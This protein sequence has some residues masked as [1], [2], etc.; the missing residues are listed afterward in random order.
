M[1]CREKAWKP[2]R[3][4]LQGERPGNSK[5]DKMKRAAFRTSGVAVMAVMMLLA[6]TGLASAKSLYVIADTNYWPTPIRAYNV[7]PDGTLTFQAEHGIADV[8]A[9]VGLAVDTATDTLFVTSEGSNIINLVDA[10]TMTGIGNTT[11][12]G[13]YD[14][15]GI[16]VDE[17]KKL[18]YTVDRYTSNLYVYKWDAVN[19]T[20]TLEQQVTLAEVGGQG[21]FGIALDKTRGLLYVANYNYGDYAYYDMAVAPGAA[22]EI[23]YYRTSDWSQAGTLEL[24]GPAIGIAVDAA[25]Q[26]LYSG[27][28]WASYSRLDYY[29]LQTGAKDGVDVGYYSGAMGIAVDEETGL[30]YITTGYD[31]DELRVYKY[32]QETANLEL[33]QNLGLIG[34]APT[35]LA[36]GS[37]YNPL[38]LEKSGANIVSPGQNLTYTLSFDNLN[39][40]EAVHNVILT[41]NL[42]PETSFVSASDGGVY[43]SET[44]EVTWSIGDLA[45]GAASRSVQLTV[46]VSAGAPIGT[47]IRNAATI[48]SDDTPPTTKSKETLVRVTPSFSLTFPVEGYTPYNAPVIAVLDHSVFETRPV[49]FYVENGRVL[50]FNGELADKAFGAEKLEGYWDGYKNSSGSDFL[51]GVL[52]YAEGPYLYYDGHPGYDYR[53]PQGT[54]I[55]AT[56]PGRLYIAQ[57]DPVNGG[58][59]QAYRTFYIKHRVVTGEGVENYYT[60]YLY[61]KLRKSIRDEVNQNGFARV[62]KGQVIGS[63][64]ND[65]VH[66]DFRRFGVRPARI[67]DPYKEVMWDEVE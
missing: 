53:V 49:E 30:V 32:N 45:A 59:W 29:N 16:V 38:N 12:P 66:V 8:G 36:I 61:V 39:N 40:P 64:Y 65:W 25:R 6:L 11:A 21:A 20:L 67:F 43:D 34:S 3:G 33:F 54:R 5:E 44:R 48:D 55:L 57:S 7:N 35:G 9:A 22:Y 26:F 42:P 14:L 10:K 17:A 24:A 41:D 27:A 19:K 62:R 56:A 18:I 23:S 50:A 51:A 2:I 63:T 31:G 4:V 37:G 46:Q 15:A 28:G 47:Y 52:N 58:G 60:W 13:A 1:S